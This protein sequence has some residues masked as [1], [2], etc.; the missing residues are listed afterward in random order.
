LG[1]QRSSR[2]RLGRYD[3]SG[4]SLKDLDI[5]GPTQLIVPI[6]IHGVSTLRLPIEKMKVNFPFWAAAAGKCSKKRMPSSRSIE[7]K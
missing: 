4:I 3:T 7:M 5:K 6:L 1:E 2:S